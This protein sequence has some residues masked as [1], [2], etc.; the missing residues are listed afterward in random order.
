MS[1]PHPSLRASTPDDEPFFRELYR[2]TRFAEFA[3]L[4]LSAAQVNALCDAQ[5]E[6]QAAGYRCAFPH[7]QHFAI[8]CAGE[9]VGRLI[10]AADARELLLVD[11]ALMPAFRG[12]G[13]GALLVRKLQDQARASALPLRLQVER[14]SPVLNWYRELGFA[15][16]GADGTH[17]SMTWEQS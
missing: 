13:W 15:V 9:R 2:M 3:Q 12:R 17:L 4:P 5:F 16:S 14:S 8:C 6:A 11:L 1:E 7:A 10:V